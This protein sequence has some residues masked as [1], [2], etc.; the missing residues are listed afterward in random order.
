MKLAVLSD[1]HGNLPALQAVLEDVERE[2]VDA[3]V[4]LGDIL[5]GPLLPRETADF[6]MTRDFVTIAGNH[7]RQVLKMK[8]AGGPLDPRNSDGHAVSRL[9]RHHFEWLRTLPPTHWLA[10]DVL[11]VH[12]T[13]STDIVYWLETVVPDFDRHGSPGMRAATAEEIAARMTTGSY[14]SRAS[15]V[16]CG[17]SHVPRVVQSGT[18]LIVNPGSVGLQAYE[19]DHGP[20]HRTE[21]GSPHA[22][23][24]LVERRPGGWSARLCSVAYDWGAME[25]L[26]A[27]NGRPD[28]A[29]ALATGRMPALGQ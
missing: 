25:R 14:D 8:D 29:H 22:R 9:E 10:H 7:E 2:R 3:V 12:G 28:W 23:Y 11:L 13:P 20:R 16:L 24:A 1:I 27:A 18:T 15:L 21:N 5:S 17:H 6:L 4:N 19:D 26:A